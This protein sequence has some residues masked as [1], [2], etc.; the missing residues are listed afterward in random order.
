M[1]FFNHNEIKY[2]HECTP[3]LLCGFIQTYASKGKKS[4]SSP[5]STSERMS[6]KETQ[7]ETTMEQQSTKAEGISWRDWSQCRK[8]SLFPIS[9][10]FPKAINLSQG[11]RCLFTSNLDFYGH[12]NQLWAWATP[13]K[14][15]TIIHW[16]TV[17][18]T[19]RRNKK[20]YQEKQTH[21][22]SSTQMG[23]YCN[24]FW[25]LQKKPGLQVPFEG[26]QDQACLKCQQN[27]VPEGRH[28]NTG[29]S[30]PLSQEKALSIQERVQ[31]V[32]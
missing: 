4:L 12:P 3:N 14:N 2:V 28:H 29:G 16:T 23:T 22:N 9:H 10:Y 7:T 5:L 11:F 27:A 17:H 15:K 19:N 6:S 26:R 32:H 20:I 31:L 13:I 24:L 8:I 30:L 1:F 18:W 25:G 21:N